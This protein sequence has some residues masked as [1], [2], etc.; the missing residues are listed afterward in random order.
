MCV[1]VRVC[2]GTLTHIISKIF[3]DRARTKEIGLQRRAK[4]TGQKMAGKVVP[5]RRRL[6]YVL[7]Y[8]DKVLVVGLQDLV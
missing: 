1:C 6:A 3:W 7:I 4:K 5:K 8:T 2:G